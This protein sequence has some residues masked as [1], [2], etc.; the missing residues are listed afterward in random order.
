MD[1]EAVNA[2]YWNANILDYAVVFGKIWPLDSHSNPLGLAPPGKS[3]IR[4]WMIYSHEYNRNVNFLARSR[5]AFL[6]AK[7]SLWSDNGYAITGGGKVFTVK[8][9]RASRIEYIYSSKFR[10][11]FKVK[12]TAA[13]KTTFCNLTRISNESCLDVIGIE[14]ESYGY[15]VFLLCP[16]ICS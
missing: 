4:P 14:E 7:Y 8:Q 6:K 2:S 10:P 11:H 16:G 3:W 12:V 13:C 15:Y 5:L 1:P 9:L